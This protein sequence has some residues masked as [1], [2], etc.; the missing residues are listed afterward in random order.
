[1]NNVDYVRENDLM[2]LH[3]ENLLWGLFGNLRSEFVDKVADLPLEAELLL[4]KVVLD[5]HKGHLHLRVYIVLILTAAV[6]GM[7]R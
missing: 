2:S 4:E 5:V 1:M 7:L 6:L 3:D